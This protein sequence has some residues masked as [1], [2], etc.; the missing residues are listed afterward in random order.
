MS[1]T[2]PIFD[3]TPIFHPV[4]GPRDGEDRVSKVT[5]S[6][7]HSTASKKP[8]SRK[9][10][11]YIALEKE[12]DTWCKN[13]TVR[14]LKTEAKEKIIEVFNK[15]K[16]Q[17]DLSS[18][19]LTSLPSSL[20]NFTHLTHLN[21][22][23]NPL[24]HVPKWIGK[25][26]NLIS[27]DLNETEIENL[28]RS[29]SLLTQLR[30]LHLSHNRFTLLPDWIGNF[31][32]L[33]ELWVSRNALVSVPESLGQLT[34]L[35]ELR[36]KDNQLQTLPESLDALST[37]LYVDLSGNPGEQLRAHTL[38]PYENLNNVERAAQAQLYLSDRGID[39]RIRGRSE[40]L[41]EVL[42]TP[43]PPTQIA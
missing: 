24:R 3:S 14:G 11:N 33:T 7:F 20:R 12:L 41:F 34:N 9:V 1:G 25:L 38:I 29:L 30:Y 27:L 4:G 17:L 15:Q 40:A 43:R 37:L 8:Y 36:L 6:A 42:Y 21:L 16:S 23:K 22:G 18:H 31:K 10:F 35:R 19:S 13:P 32:E 2:R 39:L 28:P 26:N 5:N